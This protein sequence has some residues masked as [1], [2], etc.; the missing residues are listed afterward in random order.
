MFSRIGQTR[1]VTVYKLITGESVDEDIF[2]IGERKRE[3]SDAV[4]TDHRQAAAGNGGVSKRSTD[5]AATDSSDDIGAIGW[6]LQKA[7]QKTVTKPVA[8][9]G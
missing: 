3:L 2:S 6:I 4:L 9:D 1:P 5:A 7:L 8:I